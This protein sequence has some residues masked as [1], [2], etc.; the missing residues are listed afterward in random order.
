MPLEFSECKEMIA[1]SDECSAV[2]V[3]SVNECTEISTASVLSAT[4]IES[5][6]IQFSE[7]Q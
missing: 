3:I 7:C 6:C 2:R 5:K 1:L 4:Y